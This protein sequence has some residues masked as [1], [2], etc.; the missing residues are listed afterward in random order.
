MMEM[1]LEK[2][3]AIYQSSFNIEKPYDFCGDIYEAYGFCDIT[4]TKY[5]LT[6]KAELW[7]AIC[8][9]HVFFRTVDVLMPED[10]DRFAE[11][12]AEKIE[13]ILVRKGEKCM[14]KDHMYTY[15]TGIFICEKGVGEELKKKIKKTRFFKNYRLSLRGYCELRILAIDLE[16]NCLI[17]NA[18]ARGLV[19]DYKRFL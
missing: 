14:E 3:L 10:I 17:G 8:Y 2:L 16:N 15:I 4:N 11:Q 5:V 18:A 13:P 1:M 19:K 6:Q 7:R 12:T 9:E